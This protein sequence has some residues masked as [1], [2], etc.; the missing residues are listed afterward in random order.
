[1]SINQV[2][3]ARSTKEL[4]AVDRAH[5]L[6]PLTD[7]SPM[8]E[9]GTRVITSGQGCF[10]YDSE[11]RRFLDAISA[12]WCVNVGYSRREIVDA[13]YE[14]MKKLPYYC[15]AW[16]STTEPTILLAERLTTLGPKRLKHVFFSNSGSEGNEAALKIIRFH[17]KRTGQSR[18]RKI[19]SLTNSYH[20]GTLA[21]SSMTGLKVSYEPYDLPLEG[22]VHCPAPYRY[23][24]DTSMTEI[25]YGQWCLDETA[26]IIEREGAETIAA[27]FVEPV[28]GSGGVVVPPEGYLRGL[29][30]LCRQHSIFFVADEVITGYGRTGAWFASNLWD[31]DPDF[32]NTAKGVTSGYL[33]LG[34]LFVSEEIAD[35]VIRG[36]F[37]SHVFTYSGHPAAT[38]AAMAN[39]DILESEGL[40]TRAHDSIGPYLQKRLRE[41][42]NHPAVGEVRGLGLIAAMELLPPSRQ[43][44]VKPTV[45]P[46]ALALF[47]EAGVIVRVG[48][49]T[50]AFSPPLI[51][52][53]AEVDMIIAAVAKVLDRVW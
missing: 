8:H 13:I 31:L 37:F 10:L 33:P 36:G 15:S 45:G 53:E 9:Q 30:E 38:A 46:K 20:G 41:F 27:M 22:F 29:R 6:H 1:M 42:E 7:H 39:L 32:M 21:T 47:R 17:N 18:K 43:K 5:L 40:I 14:Q 48:G 35:V 11:G 49:N 23:A 25:E 4:Q 51:I 12:L 50:V 34:A 16:N 44:E 2:R 19:L 26:R 28:Q 24:A 3:S 52:T